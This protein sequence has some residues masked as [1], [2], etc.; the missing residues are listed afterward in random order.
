MIDVARVAAVAGTT[1]SGPEPPSITNKDVWAQFKIDI[2]GKEVQTAETYSHSWVANQFGHVCLGIILGSALG[3]LL[4]T[5]FSTVFRWLG[6]PSSWRLAFPWDIVAGSVLAA[7]GVSWWEWRAYQVAT[8]DATGH[9][10]LGRKLLRDNA[11]VAA[12]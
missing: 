9:F 3:V 10:P 4:G 1:Q 6:G 5:D 7:I 2:A 11:V 8:M 12:A